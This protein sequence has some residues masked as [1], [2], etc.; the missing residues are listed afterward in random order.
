[1]VSKQKQIN[2]LYSKHFFFLFNFYQSNNNVNNV[3]IR[4]E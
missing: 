4:E 3:C 2:N 1:M